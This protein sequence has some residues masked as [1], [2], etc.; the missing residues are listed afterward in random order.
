MDCLAERFKVLAI[1]S[2]LSKKAKPDALRLVPMPMVT[3]KQRGNSANAMHYI[4]ATLDGT[5]R[6]RKADFGSPLTCM[7]NDQRVVQ[8][9]SSTGNG[10][11]ESFTDI[12]QSLQWITK[13]YKLIDEENFYHEDL[14]QYINGSIRTSGMILKYLHYLLNGVLCSVPSNLD[15]RSGKQRLETSTVQRWYNEYYYRRIK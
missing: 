3:R 14:N 4:E 2:V 11:V 12:V 1:R 8:G 5:K 13:A 9:I 10:E 6:F 15:N 7:Q